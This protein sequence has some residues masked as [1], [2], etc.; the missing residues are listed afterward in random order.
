MKNSDFKVI[1]SKVDI[2]YIGFYKPCPSLSFFG[3]TEEEALQGIIDE[4]TRVENARPF[5]EAFANLQEEGRRDIPRLIA[6]LKEIDK[7]YD[8]ITLQE[9]TK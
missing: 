1:R 4:A 8:N 3:K 7:K 6:K 9:T 2:G 5:L